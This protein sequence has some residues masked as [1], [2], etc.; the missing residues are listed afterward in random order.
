MNNIDINEGYGGKAG[1]KCE[2][3][4]GIEFKN[5]DKNDN[6]IYKV[7][8]YNQIVNP[9]GSP[10]SFKDST[11]I[12][13]SINNY[14]PSFTGKRTMYNPQ[15]NFVSNPYSQVNKQEYK[16]GSKLAIISK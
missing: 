5:A 10:I 8:E 11:L 3:K 12:L 7:N 13:Y 16:V 2:L 4:Q 9:N 14:Q 6:T 15:Y 1:L